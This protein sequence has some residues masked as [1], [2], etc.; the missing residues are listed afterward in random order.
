M[1]L[2][3]AVACLHTA[4]AGD[5]IADAKVKSNYLHHFTKFVEWPSLVNDTVHI[6]VVGSEQIVNQLSEIASRDLK[7]HALQIWLGLDEPGI[8]QILFISRTEKDPGQLMNLVRGNQVLT[9]SDAEG[10]AKQGGG[11]GFYDDAGQVRL[12]INP[13]AIQSA[14]LKLNAMLMEIARIVR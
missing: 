7:G 5:E 6:C 1:V 4:M 11:I 14:R 12:E 8:C 13:D 9:V 10:F 2:L 3:C